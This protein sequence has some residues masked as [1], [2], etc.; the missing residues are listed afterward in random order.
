MALPVCEVRGCHLTSWISHTG[1]I[2]DRAEDS[3]RVHSGEVVRASITS[4]AQEMCVCAGVCTE[5]QVETGR[6]VCI[7]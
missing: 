3:N 4:D 6:P 2:T 5:S 1:I 7:V